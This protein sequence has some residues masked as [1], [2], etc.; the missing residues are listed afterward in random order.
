MKKIMLVSQVFCHEC[1]DPIQ[2]GMAYKVGEWQYYHPRCLE[3]F[4]HLRNC[5]E[6]VE[7]EYIQAKAV[8]HEQ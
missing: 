1:W 3:D 8:K 2:K 7:L 6:L 4:Q 5:F